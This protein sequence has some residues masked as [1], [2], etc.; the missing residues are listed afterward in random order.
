MVS[1]RQVE[2]PGGVAGRLYLHSMPGRYE[3]LEEAWAEVKRLGISTII[4]LAPLDEIREKSP[5]YSKSIQTDAVPC[6]V[7]RLPVCDYQ[8]PDDDRAFSELSG[9]VA[10][11]LRRGEGILIHCGAGVGRT[12]MFA[13]AALM[14]LG[15]SS[16]EARRQ[17]KAAGSGP[18]RPAQ[19]EALR[20]FGRVRD[21][22]QE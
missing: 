6:D 21:Q 12:G 2:L 16:D 8:G 19:E 13:I 9:R 5:E 18:E 20:R 17:V 7:R 11:L 10:D 3:P 22:A 14:T 1:F 4:C 15:L